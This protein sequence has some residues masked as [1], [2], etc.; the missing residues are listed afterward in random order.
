MMLMWIGSGLNKIERK[1]CANW[2][3]RGNKYGFLCNCPACVES[4]EASDR[5]RTW[6]RNRDRE[7]Q[8]THVVIEV[9]RDASMW[10]TCACCIM[11]TCTCL[12]VMQNMMYIVCKCIYDGKC[13]RIC[14]CWSQLWNWYGLNRWTIGVL[15]PPRW[16]SCFEKCGRI[17]M[18]KFD[19]EIGIAPPKRTL[20]SLLKQGKGNELNGQWEVNCN[21]AVLWCVACLVWWVFKAWPFQSVGSSDLHVSVL[22]TDGQ[23]PASDKSLIGIRISQSTMTND[24]VYNSFDYLLLKKKHNDV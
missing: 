5:R 7:V 15:I 10:E 13:I 4:S 9:L 17:D 20:E 23:T 11:W 3:L 24:E 6:P 12:N 8:H 19:K 16:E 22:A 14:I 21:V 1:Y 18:V 2:M